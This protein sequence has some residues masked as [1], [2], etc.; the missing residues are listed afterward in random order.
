M[1][2]V[3]PDAR[4]VQLPH[5]ARV[6]LFGV[7]SP[8][9]FAPPRHGVFPLQRQQ[10]HRRF[11]HEGH[12]FLVK[13]LAFVHRVEALGL[14]PRQVLPT[15][16][17]DPEAVFLDQ[18]YNRARVARRH[19]VGLDDCQCLVSSCHNMNAF[20]FILE[21]APLS[22]LRRRSR[23]RRSAPHHFYSFSAAF[24][25]TPISAGV[26][27]TTMPASSIAA[28]LSVAFPEPPEMI[29]P[30]WP[31]RRPGGAVCP[32]MNPTTGFL[33]YSLM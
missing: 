13:A 1:R 32:A 18:R 22:S 21:P 6:G 15:H 28:I 4:A 17:P 7:R 12:Q 16:R 8:H 23:G 26:A 14:G 31:M 3:A 25:L 27:H 9:H 29:A 24:T 19:R 20:L 11:A 5:R 2:R 10:Y 33:P 30:E